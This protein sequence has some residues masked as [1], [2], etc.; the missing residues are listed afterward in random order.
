MTPT[1]IIT[2]LIYR[3]T[4]TPNTTRVQCQTVGNAEF[5]I[6]TTSE[7]SISRLVG[8]HGATVTALKALA[9]SMQP[10]LQVTLLDPDP[11][12]NTPKTQPDMKAVVAAL[13]ERLKVTAAIQ[14]T[15]TAIFIAMPETLPE[16]L[17]LTL[18]TLFRACGQKPKPIVAT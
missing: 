13:F 9:E 11:M 4:P 18:T 10:R 8:K 6:I 7:S 1:E 17:R 15:D 14:E 5:L 16:T 12:P 2:A 3:I